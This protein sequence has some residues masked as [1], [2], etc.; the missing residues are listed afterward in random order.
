[1]ILFGGSGSKA[2][3]K[4]LRTIVFV[5]PKGS[6]DWGKGH[7]GGI[8][9]V[10][11]KTGIEISMNPGKSVAGGRDGTDDLLIRKKRRGSQ[12]GIGCPPMFRPAWVFGP[13]G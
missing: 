9:R 13:S 2:K 8:P 3:W 10:Q 6:K 12:R 7:P 5:L 4:T 1:M 11:G